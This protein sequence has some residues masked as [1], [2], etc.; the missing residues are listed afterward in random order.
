MKLT[1]TFYRKEYQPCTVID[2]IY[3]YKHG[4]ITSSKVKECINY[5]D[6]YFPPRFDYCVITYRNKIILCGVPEK[7]VIQ[8]LYP[9]AGRRDFLGSY[10][11]LPLSLK[12][13]IHDMYPTLVAMA[14]YCNTS[15]KVAKDYPLEVNWKYL[16]HEWIEDG[17]LIPF[18]LGPEDF[19]NG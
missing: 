15:F 12:R 1:I 10:N 11:S 7:G 2:S 14:N 9:A 19:I 16:V 3:F 4:W 6:T 18:I 5:I 17:K 8:W 13:D